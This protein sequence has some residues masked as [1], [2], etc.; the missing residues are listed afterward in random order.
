[1][2]YQVGFTSRAEKQLSS[3]PRRVQ[4][5]ILDKADALA[6]SPRGT[7]VVKLKD[8]G[9][10]PV[11]RLRAG[12]DYRILFTIDDTAQSVTIVAVGPRKD[13]YRGR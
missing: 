11:Y 1:M 3:L 9:E 5:R 13:I 6:D 4:A 8:G 12:R 7:G 2:V 10:P